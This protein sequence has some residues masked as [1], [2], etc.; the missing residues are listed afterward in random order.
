MKV[1]EKSQNM[2]PFFIALRSEEDAK[3]YVESL[4]RFISIYSSFL[5]VNPPQFA[6]IKKEEF[7]S[8]LAQDTSRLFD[9]EICIRKFLKG[10]KHENH[11]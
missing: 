2:L 4:H 7:L 10:E 3:K 1:N 6:H 9:I 5:W 11:F 8:K